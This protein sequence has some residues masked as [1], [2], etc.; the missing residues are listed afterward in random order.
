MWHRKSFVIECYLVN[1]VLREFAESQSS[2]LIVA[3][4]CE[5]HYEQTLI[6]FSASAAAASLSSSP[7]CS[8]AAEVMLAS[9]DE[10]R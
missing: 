2:I 8:L 10:Q 1:G 5:F 3:V 4:I 7:G 9:N 6:S